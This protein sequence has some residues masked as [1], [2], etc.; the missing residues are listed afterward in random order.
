MYLYLLVNAETSWSQDV[1]HI[2]TQLL[3]SVLANFFF[4]VKMSFDLCLTLESR[5][6]VLAFLS[7]C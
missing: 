4:D 3:A 1:D 7:L 5:A 6:T 2:V